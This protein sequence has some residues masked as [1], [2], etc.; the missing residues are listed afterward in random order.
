MY[1]SSPTKLTHIGVLSA[2]V[3]S[4]YCTILNIFSIDGLYM[5]Y[6]V[7]RHHATTLY[8]KILWFITFIPATVGEMSATVGEYPRQWGE[9]SA[10]VGEMSATVGK[11]NML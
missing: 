8:I 2:T 10:T 5:V 7:D 6:M 11:L 1:R 3:G 9:M 4:Y